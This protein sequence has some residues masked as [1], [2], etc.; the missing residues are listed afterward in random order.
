M[1]Q[2]V[3]RDP[4]AAAPAAALA[5]QTVYLYGSLV[6]RAT[7]QWQEAGAALI[8]ALANRN[9]TKHLGDIHPVHDPLEMG[10]QPWESHQGGQSAIH[11]WSPMS[12]AGCRSCNCEA[13]PLIGSGCPSRDSVRAARLRQAPRALPITKLAAEQ[14]QQ[15]AALCSTGSIA[16]WSLPGNA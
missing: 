16:H 3:G 14:G 11:I 10:D 9:I 5:R 7:M 6:T 4:A 15:L 13:P 8:R 1:I 12:K 2:D